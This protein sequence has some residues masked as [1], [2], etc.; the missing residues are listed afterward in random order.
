M[1]TIVAGRH[2]DEW[3]MGSTT[4]CFKI[5]YQ[6]TQRR[7]AGHVHDQQPNLLHARRFSDIL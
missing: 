4:G 5:F 7:Y 3:E 1:P 2:G 6:A